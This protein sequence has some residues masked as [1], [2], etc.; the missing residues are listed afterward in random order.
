MGGSVVPGKL[1]GGGWAGACVTQHR[2]CV[3]VGLVGLWYPVRWVAVGVVGGTGAGHKAYVVVIW[4]GLWPPV[5]W[6]SVGGPVR[7]LH[8]TG[9]VW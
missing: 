5:N 3:V 6:V 8:S 7:V 9:P 1:D 2:A 4:V